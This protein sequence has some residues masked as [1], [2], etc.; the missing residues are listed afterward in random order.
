[1]DNRSQLGNTQD[2]PV[3]PRPLSNGHSHQLSSSS[4]CTS[5]SSLAESEANPFGFALCIEAYDGAKVPDLQ[6]LRLVEDQLEKMEQDGTLEEVSLVYDDED[7]ARVESNKKILRPPVGD[8]VH[9]ECAST[10]QQLQQ[11]Q[12]RQLVAS[13]VTLATY[14]HSLSSTP[15]SASSSARPPL[16]ILLHCHDG[17]TETSLLALTYIMYSRRCCLPEAYSWLQLQADRS[18][19]V[20]AQD[21][22]ILEAIECRVRHVLEREREERFEDRVTEEKESAGM[23][24]SDSGFASNTSIKSQSQSQQNGVAELTIFEDLAL[25]KTKSTMTRSDMGLELPESMSPMTPAA[26][27]KHSSQLASSESAEERGGENGKAKGN[28]AISI[29]KE[30]DE[31]VMPIASPSKFPWFY[32]ETW[33]GS[34]PSRILPFVSGLIQSI[35]S[36]E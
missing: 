11:H 7:E 16:R 34:F 26:T 23:A 24:R 6:A 15:A 2:L 4:T 36:F 28:E 20:S 1:M 12:Q 17:Y 13:T 8:I 30:E 9:L 27:Q 29:E 10:G 21:V 25:E 31:I 19:F 5:L 35:I 18:F 14:I 3:P 33:E 22:A 32:G